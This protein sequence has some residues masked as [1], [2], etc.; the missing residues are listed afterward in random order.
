MELREYISETLVQITEGI[1]TAMEKLDGKGVIINPNSTYHSDGRFWIGKQMEHSC[2]MRWVQ[3]IDM[4]ISTIVTESTEG[5][6]GA[7]INVGVL[8]VGGGMKDVGSE[9]KTNTIK[10][11]IPICLPCTNV[12]GEQE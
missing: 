6:G 12:L 9:Q 1:N 3:M 5:Q 10:F 8:N 2:V 11:S 4:N 7:K